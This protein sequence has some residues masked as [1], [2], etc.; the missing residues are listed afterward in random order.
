MVEHVSASASAF[1]REV[2]SHL[3]GSFDRITDVRVDKET[4]AISWQ[5]PGRAARALSWLSGPKREHNLR[6]VANAIATSNKFQLRK[7]DPQ[8]EHSARLRLTQDRAI[9]TLKSDKFTKH[10]GRQLALSLAS[11]NQISAQ[12]E[13]SPISQARSRLSLVADAIDKTISTTGT[14]ETG[15]TSKVLQ[16]VSDKLKDASQDPALTL[17]RAQRILGGIP[18]VLNSVVSTSQLQRETDVTATLQ[19]KLDLVREIAEQQHQIVS[20]LRRQG[21]VETLSSTPTRPNQTEV[22]KSAD[23]ASGTKVNTSAQPVSKSATSFVRESTV[24]PGGE[25]QLISRQIGNCCFGHSAEA[26]FNKPIF[27]DTAHFKEVRNS[28]AKQGYAEIFGEETAAAV[29]A[30]EGD[31]EFTTVESAKLVLNRLK[32]ADEKTATL[33]DFEYSTLEI[34]RDPA[35]WEIQSVEGRKEAARRNTEVVDQF[36]REVAEIS[37]SDRFVVRIGSAAGHFLSLIKNADGSWTSV[38]SSGGQ[39][40]TSDSPYEALVDSPHQR[41]LTL[42][43]MTQTQLTQAEFEAR[44]Q[45]PRQT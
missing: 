2:G 23:F 38:N 37:S 39:I 17:S 31:E 6:A 21:P 5:A 41:S 20:E 8:S 1:I 9:E 28:L 18:G 33:G 11:L 42:A 10:Q 26:Y 44:T 3:N 35:N 14:P 43:V 25:P 13:D 34:D 32:T 19:S 27:R 12:A 30:N 15:A 45:L 36:I 16:S 24:L 22:T 40:K 29:I 7:L 4:G